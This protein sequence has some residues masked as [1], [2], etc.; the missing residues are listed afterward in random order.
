[1][2]SL[3]RRLLAE[4]NGR[5]AGRLLAIAENPALNDLDQA[6]LAA[7]DPLSR[8]R[9]D[10]GAKRLPMLALLM[11]AEAAAM[12]A[13]AGAD[14]DGP[15]AEE[16]QPLV[17]QAM[18]LLHHSDQEAAKFGA[19]ALARASRYDPG[20]A[21]YSTALIA[22]PSDEVRSVA[23]AV[24]VLDD[25]AQRI[26]AADP[27]PQVRAKLAGRARELADDV[28][29]S[30]RTDTHVDVIRVLATATESDKPPACRL[31]MRG[32]RTNRTPSPKSLAVGRLD[33]SCR[34]LLSGLWADS[35]S[36]RLIPFGSA[37]EGFGHAVGGVLAEGGRDVR[38]ALGLAQ[39]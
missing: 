5:L 37:P 12:A 8:G 34:R 26:L 3:L 25:T 15:P 20:L 23:A 16:M 36:A 18:G 7:Q 13:E 32:R 17:T 33:A 35:A 29:A 27:S 11:A 9:L 28:I 39:L 14:V 1:V 24:A 2:R 10:T 38:V 4:E 22:H 6:E 30:L 31:R 21:A 19:A